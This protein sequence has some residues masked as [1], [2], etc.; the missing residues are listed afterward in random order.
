MDKITLTTFKNE[1]LTYRKFVFSGGEIQIRLDET[2]VI[3][4]EVVIR[5]D[6]RT[7]SGI[8]ELLLVTYALRQK[9]IS[10]TKIHLT[11]PYLPYARQDRVCSPGEAFSLEVM[12]RLL[13]SQ[14]YAT[15]QL[16]DVHS[17]VSL[18]LLPNAYNV[19]VADLI[20]GSKMPSSVFSTTVFVSPDKGAINRVS[21]CAEKFN[22]PMI[23]AEKIRDPK[24]GII[25]GTKIVDGDMERIDRG[26]VNCG[27]GFLMIDDICDG[28]RTFIELAKV[29]RPMTTGEI[30]LYVTHLIASQGFEV[31]Y[32]LIDEIYTSNCFHE[33][34][35]DF[36]HIV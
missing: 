7:A 12:C 6:L 25:T 35:P 2:D 4:V 22:R 5:A 16:W 36:V 20:D 17:P 33:D 34:V 14:N 13:S 29:L 8:M 18:K 32:G 26:D 15:I 24:T 27:G 1:E 23:V 19:L 10:A 21:G 11:L 3:P 28:G 31:F 30:R 9:Y